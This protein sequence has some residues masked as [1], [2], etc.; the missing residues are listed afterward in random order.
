ML[1]T[2]LTIL[3]AAVA[4][5]PFFARAQETAS[6]QPAKVATA[7]PKRQFYRLDFVIREVDG[8]HV[9]NSRSYSLIASTDH[10]F[11]SIRTGN[12]VP[13]ANSGQYTDVGVSIDCRD[14]EELGD[15]LSINVTAELST[16]PDTSERGSGGLPLIRQN[17]W[18]SRVLLP[19]KHPT[20]LFSSDDLA[21][22]RKLQLELTATPIQ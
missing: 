5:C 8:G 20:V 9:T 2:G 13:V 7:T 6:A 17:R 11:N 18:S 14:A 1:K 16:I 3:A 10:A 4:L 19:L 21:S 15:Q 12:K 22:T